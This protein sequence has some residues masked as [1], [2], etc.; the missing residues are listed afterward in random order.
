LERRYSILASFF[1]TRCFTWPPLAAIHTRVVQAREPVPTIPNL[2]T[3][4]AIECE[5]GSVSFAL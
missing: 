5:A 1:N 2:P 3:H 4:T